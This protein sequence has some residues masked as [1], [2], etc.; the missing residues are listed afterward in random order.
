V[1][2]AEERFDAELVA[3]V[4]LGL[5]ST[6]AL[7]WTY[8]DRFAS[9][10]EDRLRTHD[11]PVLAAAD[12][13]SYLHL[14]IVAGILVF[15]AGVKIAVHDVGE[16]IDDA[17]RLALCGG[18]A[19]YLLGN[20]AFRLRIAGAL[21]VENLIAA[22][23]LLVLYLAGGELEAWVLGA[24]VTVVLG[25]MCAHETVSARRGEPRRATA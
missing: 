5:L 14:V 7:W 20:V 15:A 18:V 12:A 3:G 24:V 11:D 10:A 17:T 1:G 6:V 9:I 8:F 16:P 2:A 25:A 13:Y 23:A 19:L 4:T 21:G 22:A